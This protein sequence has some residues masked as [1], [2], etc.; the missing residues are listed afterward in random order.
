MPYEIIE[1]TA[2]NKK[3]FRVKNMETGK[4]YSRTAIPLAHA[5]KQRTILLASETN[6]DNVKPR[7]SGRV[8]NPLKVPPIPKRN[9]D[10]GDVVMTAL[11]P[12]ERVLSVQQNMKLENMIK[13]RQIPNFIGLKF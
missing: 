2:G 1:S 4:F 13:Q 8:G 7:K 9:N 6:W 5:K 3:G 11:E 10:Y 12:N